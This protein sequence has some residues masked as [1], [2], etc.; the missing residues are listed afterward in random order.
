[1][2]LDYPRSLED[3]LLESL[4]IEGGITKIRVSGAGGGGGTSNTEYTEGDTDATIVGIVSMAEGAANA[5]RPTQVFELSGTYALKTAIVDGSGTQITSFGGGV[6]YTE[7]DVDASITGTALMFEDAGNTLSVAPGTAADGLLVNLGAN[8]DVTVSGTVAATQ[9]GTWNITNISGTVSLPTGAA[10]ET[11]LSSINSGLSSVIDTIGNAIGTEILLVGGEDPS[12]NAKPFQTATDGDIIAH[13]HSD[14]V[15]LPDG[16]SN[17][18]RIPVNE[19]DFGYMGFPCLPY[20]F[21][22]TTWDR[23]RGDSTNGLTVNLGSNNDVTVT[24]TVAVTQSGTWVLGSNSGVDI[25]DVTINN[26]SGASA[27][28]I[29]DGGN[30]ITVDNSALSVVGGGLE[31]TALRVTIASDSTGVLS[32]DDNGGSL[33]VDGTVAATQSGTWNITNISGTVSLP[34]GAA[35]ETTLSAINAKLSSGTSTLS[36]VSASATSVTVL[37]SNSS[38]KKAILRNDSTSGCYVKY[39]AT[40][41]STSHTI[42]LRAGETL[43]EDGQG[44]YTGVIDAIWD[45]AT[46]TMRVTEIT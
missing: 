39:G 9:S 22:G 12:G 37:A 5:I 31:A 10:T 40:A 35:T 19:T 21:N 46:G 30:S 27:V 14:A 44:L 17:T 32:V 6:Q 36:N 25:G 3:G 16:V 38:R 43:I 28:N 20:M 4:V 33:T 13:L 18:I 45:S 23:V 26:A 2:A 42:R 7:G 15:A 8:N 29:Q 41:S 34:T 1:M 24:G 11:T